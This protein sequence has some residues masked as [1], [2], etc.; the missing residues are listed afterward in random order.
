M[1]KTAPHQM[2]PPE[3]FWNAIRKKS[4]DCTP[5]VPKIWLDWTAQN[6]YITPE[7]ALRSPQDA[8][9][10]IVRACMDM[11]FDAARLF[12]FTPRQVKIEDGECIQYLHGR[13]AGK[14][15]LAGGWSTTLVHAGDFDIENPEV[16]MNPQIY[17]C[18]Q[19]KDYADEDVR[20]IA[21]PSAS[22][23]EQ[24]GYGAYLEKA[25]ALAGERIGLIG[26]CNS[27]TLSFYVALR[28]MMNGLVDLIDAP[29]MVHAVMEKG[30]EIAIEKAKL[31][32]AHGIKVLRYNDSSANMK[33]I[34]PDMWREFIAPH[35]RDFCAAVH[36]MDP[37]ARVY[38]HICGDV[39]PILHDLL[40]TG[41]D[42]IAPLDPLGCGSV[43]AVRQI[44]GSDA[45]LMGGVDTLQL[46]SGTPDAVYQQA[47]A[48]IREGGQGYILGSGCAVARDT[49]A[50]NLR[51]MVRAAH[52]A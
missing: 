40:M 13:A 41:L 5:V 42:C 44:I 38:C 17:A 35:L 50:E 7:D 20:R 49:P 11:G 34:S 51:A 2:T 21:V 4:V 43:Q 27:G 29:E 36:Q 1:C 48:C 14:V 30:I 26:D 3:R 33:L 6:G 16:T 47:L 37:E 18:T 19:Y 45:A 31:L 32:L 10:S 12:L 24:Q 9:L 23:Y 15:D 39:R 28:G 46:L 8:M 22:W 25:K 52:H